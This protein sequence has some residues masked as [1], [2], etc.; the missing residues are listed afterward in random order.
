MTVRPS[1]FLAL[2]TSLVIALAPGLAGAQERR[3]DAWQ[4]LTDPTGSLSVG[5]LP[6]EGWRP[7]VANRSWNAQFD[8]LRDY[9]GV[10]WYKT[11]IEIPP[12]ARKGRV[13][14]RFGAVDYFADVF[15]N[16]TKASSHEGA[17]T[18]FTVDI[19]G[20]TRDG[21]NELVVR[22]IDPPP[23]PP[24]APPRF[25][26]MPY[27]ELP[28]GKQNWYIQNGGLWQPVVLEIRPA[29]FIGSVKVTA[30]TNGAVEAAINVVGGPFSR[31]VTVKSIVRGPDGTV[32]AS[33]PDARVSVAG[34]VTVTGSVAS[35]R[36]WSPADPA[37]YTVEASL[38]GGPPHRVVARFGFREFTARDGQFFLNGQPFYMR[39][40]LDQDFY[41]DSIYS[42]PDKAFVVDMMRKG[43]TLGLNL[44]RCHIKVC[45]PTYLDAADEVGML[46]W[47]EVPSWDR[48]TPRS[49]ERG[50][51]TF[52]DMVARDWN[53]P[54]IVIQSLI[55]EAWGIDMTKPDQRAGLR[56][57]FDAAKTRVAPL[58]RLI[59]DNS[60]CC[61]NFHVKSDI[62]DFHQYFS[63]PDN[64]D[65]WDKWVADFAGRPAWSYSPHGDASRTGAEP[66]VVSEFGNWGLPQLPQSLP[67]W[68]PRDFDGRAITRPA[69]LF[70][71]FKALGFSRL[72][73]DYGAL[74]TE[75]QWRQFQSLKHEIESLRRHEPIR[76]Y[77]ITEFTD[78]NWEANGLMDMWRRPKAYA[79][80]LADI[81]Q[82]D[83]LLP[84]AEKTGIT[85]G[86]PIRL[87]VSL[88]RYGEI[89]PAGGK[90][91]YEGAGI[92][93]GFMPTPSVA[94]G[95]VG[96]IA[97]VELK[98]IHP[99]ISVTIPTRLR[100][101]LTLRS[102]A[103]QVIA[104][105]FQEVFVYPA[106]GAPVEAVL[107]DS[108]G[109][110][111]MLPWKPR[112]ATASDVVVTAVF[113]AEMRTFVENGGKVLVV[114]RGVLGTFAAAPGLSAVD[115]RDELDGNWVSNF[116]WVDAK[117]AVFKDA[118]VSTITGAEAA[119]ATPRRLIAGVPEAAW[120]AGDVLAGNF[121]G[122]LNSSHAVVAQFRLGK[123]KVIVSTFDIDRYGND[124]FAT[125][126]M[127]GL[128][129]YLASNDCSPTTELE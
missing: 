63:I 56:E 79:E 125:R 61:E 45:D 47:Y 115:R 50:R 67:W 65:R 74:A 119:G 106:A 25:P 127:D 107:H 22:V 55:N 9:F 86:E 70:D 33:L 53:H 98:T 11:T 51:Q 21:A 101:A 73:A 14:V 78:I 68:F 23:T 28:R 99:F 12:V 102:A 97:D 29:V 82:D 88:S 10:A 72:F 26:D 84:V 93:G 87:S 48:W 94:R 129:R 71:R 41:A 60:A 64:A 7:A 111:S 5:A 8:D 114:P 35:P 100:V 40:A 66:L 76:G 62:D 69:G 108:H 96:H 109:A 19:T 110:L 58:G 1:L 27:E 6:A 126:L 112:P 124:L 36:L 54:S 3:L 117:S 13:L 39:G 95:A 2:V 24:S 38:T 118:A 121:Y 15:V 113:D 85:V 92:A 57:W 37:L 89:D 49:V 17:Y 31:I 105:N 75:S 18:P 83:V 20:V 81:Q 42:T 128:I 30:N 52:D 43:R 34:P 103:G 59:V 32:V 46:V 120:A 80:A 90:L 116:P 104:K 91:E 77:V 44:L 16:G 4:F 123:G 122:W